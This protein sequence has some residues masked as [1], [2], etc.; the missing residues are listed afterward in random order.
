M[1]NRSTSRGRK[2]PIDILFNLEHPDGP[3]SDGTDVEGD[4]DSPVTPEDEIADENDECVPTD[5][6]LWAT[7]RY[8]DFLQQRRTELTKRMNAFIREKAGL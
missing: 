4:E 5:P 2:K 7:N 1:A 3:P 6:V 8:R